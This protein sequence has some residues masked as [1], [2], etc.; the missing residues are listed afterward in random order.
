MKRTSIIVALIVVGIIIILAASPLGLALA[1][2]HLSLTNGI[3]G[4]D[5]QCLIEG[6][7]R[8]IQ[9]IGALGAGFGIVKSGSKKV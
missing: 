2:W 6:Y 8:S 4:D 9:I 1:H 5:F 7:I 3:G